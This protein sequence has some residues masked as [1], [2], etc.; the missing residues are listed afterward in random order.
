M[1]RRV[2]LSTLPVDVSDVL[3][4]QEAELRRIFGRDV[5]GKDALFYQRYLYSEADFRREFVKTAKAAGSPP[6]LVYT[7]LK[8]GLMPVEG[9]KLSLAKRKQVFSA[10]RE[11]ER[12]VRRTDGNPEDLLSHRVMG[13]QPLRDMRDMCIIIGSVLH[14]LSVVASKP[15][16]PKR[17]AHVQFFTLEIVRSLRA[18]LVLLEQD[19]TFDCFHIARAM[20]EANLNL[21]AVLKLP[22]YGEVCDAA[23]GLKLGTHKYQITPKGK[24]DYSALVRVND[25]AVTRVPTRYALATQL[26]TFDEQLYDVAYRELSDLVHSS[27]GNVTAFLRPE[28]LTYLDVDYSIGVSSIIFFVVLLAANELRGAVALDEPHAADLIRLEERAF[29]SCTA[30]LMGLR[31]RTKDRLSS[32]MHAKLRELGSDPALGVVAGV[33]RTQ[34]P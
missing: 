7:F 27:F 34:F 30:M 9:V 12:L 24:S 13:E 32:L 25:G 17:L 23:L 20:Y 19:I 10:Q 14:G 2:R 3:S 28:G 22:S 8:T 29:L 5:T 4:G 11:Y 33:Y 16:A 21:T 15:R 18:A 26:G 6:I 31:T 1:V